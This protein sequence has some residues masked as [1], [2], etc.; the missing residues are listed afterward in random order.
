MH[1]MREYGELLEQPTHAAHVAKLFD[2][3]TR[4][5][6]LFPYENDD[7]LLTLWGACLLHQQKFASGIEKEEVL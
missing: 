5:I 1:D 7:S 2:T 6:Q 4:Y 3:L